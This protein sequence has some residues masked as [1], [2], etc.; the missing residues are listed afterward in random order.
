MQMGKPFGLDGIIRVEVG[1][2][3]VLWQDFSAD[4]VETTLMLKW[5]SPNQYLGFLAPTVISRKEEGW[6]LDEKREMETW[7]KI[8]PGMTKRRFWK[9]K[10]VGRRL[11]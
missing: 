1:F 5:S 2:E 7:L 10:M 9:E 3:V 4:N 6:P 8:S 11:F